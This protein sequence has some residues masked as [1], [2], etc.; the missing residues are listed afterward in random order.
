[1][2]YSIIEKKASITF[3]SSLVIYIIIL[4]KS[5]YYYVVSLTLGHYKLDF[6][7]LI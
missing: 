7:T 2:L 6:R 4:T 1:M 3:L 5:R